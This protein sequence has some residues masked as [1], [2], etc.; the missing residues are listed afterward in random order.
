LSQW[1]EQIEKTKEMVH[2]SNELLK[3]IGDPKSVIESVSSVN[4]AIDQLDYIFRNDTTQSMRETVNG[5][6]SIDKSTKGLGKEINESV[7][8]ANGKKVKRNH[9]LYS[10]YSLLD[11]TYN[12]FE[13]IVEQDQKIQK[14][15]KDRQRVLGIEHEGATNE[16][17]DRSRR[18]CF[19]SR[20]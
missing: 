1:A 20:W 8:V 7:E 12:K 2:N 15:E 18:G 17:S 5:L 9:T 3:I 4:G 10:A 13:D 16:W 19:R 14:R 6:D 11:R